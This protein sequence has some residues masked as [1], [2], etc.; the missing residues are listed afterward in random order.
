MDV[1]TLQ[2]RIVGPS[3][4]RT[5]YLLR[6]PSAYRDLLRDL[7]RSARSNLE[8]LIAAPFRQRDPQNGVVRGWILGEGHQSDGDLYTS[9]TI[10][11]SDTGDLLASTESGRYDIEKPLHRASPSLGS[12]QELR[13]WLVNDY[14]L[15]GFGAEGA[16]D[17]A[18]QVAWSLACRRYPEMEPTTDAS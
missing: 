8:P 17:P 15:F 3:A 7:P 2:T 4:Y 9:A 11:L 14:R 12:P 6:T 10:Y 16:L 18:A 13:A 1:A 5:H